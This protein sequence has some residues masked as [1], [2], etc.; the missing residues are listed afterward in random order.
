VWGSLCLSL[1]F[2]VDPCS[3]ANWVSGLPTNWVSGASWCRR[4]KLRGRARRPEWTSAGGRPKTD[5]DVVEH[6]RVGGQVEA[7]YAPRGD[8]DNWVSGL[9][10]SF[11]KRYLL[12]PA[13][14]NPRPSAKDRNG[15]AQGEDR[16]ADGRLE[17]NVFCLLTTSHRVP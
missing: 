1:L 4:G 10:A 6:G 16:R 7:A 11:L 15:R 8:E 13:R 9:P 12:V 5:V 3:A 17:G 2:L 14:K